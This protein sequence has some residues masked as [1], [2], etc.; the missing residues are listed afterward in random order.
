MLSIVLQI[1]QLFHYQL[2]QVQAAF[3]M[4]YR[5]GLKVVASYKDQTLVN[6]DF[7]RA[8]FTEGLGTPC[9]LFV[10]SIAVF[11]TG[12]AF[13]KGNTMQKEQDLTI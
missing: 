6:C 11:I 1:L 2:Q 9:W 7:K 3:Q 10:L 4:L 13:Q 8:P 12:K 5:K